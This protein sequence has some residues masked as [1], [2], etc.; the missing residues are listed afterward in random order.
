MP[1]YCK[2]EDVIRACGL[3]PSSLPKPMTKADIEANISDAEAEID[4]MTNTTYQPTTVTEIYDGTGDD[5]LY[6]NNYPIISLDSLTINNTSITT[7]YVSVYTGIEGAGRIKLKSTAE[8]TAF[9]DSDDQLIEVTYTYGFNS[10]PNIV[11]RAT[12]NIAARLTLAQQ[13]GGTYDDLSSFTIGEFSGTIGQAYINIREAFNM[14][15]EEWEK[16][17][18]P[19]LRILPDVA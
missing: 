8:K 17:I 2:Y 9:D 4:E 1:V 19:H 18:R 13:V 16:T 7:S 10:V 6:L 15:K 12:A 11:K 3:D 14:L 5:T